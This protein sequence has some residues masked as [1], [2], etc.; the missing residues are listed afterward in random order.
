[1]MQAV[2]LGINT[3]AVPLL[4]AGSKGSPTKAIAENLLKEMLSLVHKVGISC[5]INEIHVV[6][7]NPATTKVV[8]TLFD[9]HVSSEWKR[10][11]A[12]EAQT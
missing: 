9:E 12:I 7:K 2:E 5:S 8:V 3:I 4:G 10:L 1:M 11:T 6:N